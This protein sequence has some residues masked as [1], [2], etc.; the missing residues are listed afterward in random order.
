MLALNPIDTFEALPNNLR[1]SAIHPH[2]FLQRPIFETFRKA[3]TIQA[4][5]AP[6]KTSAPPANFDSIRPTLPLLNAKPSAIPDINPEVDRTN[7]QSLPDILVDPFKD[8]VRNKRKLNAP[9]RLP[10]TQSPELLNASHRESLDNGEGK[11]EVSIAP[12]RMTPRQR[13]SDAESSENDAVIAR[14]SYEEPVPVT[15]SNRKPSVR[16]TSV[17]RGA[18]EDNAPKVSKKS[19]RPSNR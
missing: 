7:P 18:N 13:Q 2:R 15:V 16:P 9:L 17:P 4:A 10:S 5:R 14:S 1:S 11:E 3:I 8:D 19:V 6:R 12:P